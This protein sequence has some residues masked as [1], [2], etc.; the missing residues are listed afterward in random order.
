MAKHQATPDN[1]LD[2]TSAKAISEAVKPHP[3][4]AER[5]ESMRSR[6]LNRIATTPAPAPAGTLTVRADERGW[7]AITPQI[8]IKVLHR[9]L[10]QNV[11][12]TL[13]RVQPGAFVPPHYHQLN[14]EC[15]VLEGE[16]K[17]GD[18]IVRQGDM[19]IALAGHTHPK[20]E[21]TTGALLLL[22]A[23]IQDW[24]SATA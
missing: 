9:D 2:S 1:E 15:L 6:I 5:K 17:V 13:W 23:E 14:E 19:H 16:I 18:H 20:V 10:E 4:T 24:P 12:T 8:E 21:S 3:L 11:Q 7:I 22:R